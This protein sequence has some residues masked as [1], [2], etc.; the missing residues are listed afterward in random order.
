MRMKFDTN[1]WKTSRVASKFSDVCEKTEYE[2]LPFQ[3]LNFCAQQTFDAIWN[4]LD[5]FCANN[6]RDELREARG[7]EEKITTKP[8]SQWMKVSEW[9]DMAFIQSECSLKLTDYRVR[10]WTNVDNQLLLHWFK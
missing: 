2:S 6:F 5:Q 3:W 1:D 8:V 10:T 9:N 4:A 7:T